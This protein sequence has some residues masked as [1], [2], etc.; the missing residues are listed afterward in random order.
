M[1]EVVDVREQQ[2]GLDP[3]R[4][5]GGQADRQHSLRPARIQHRIPELGRVLGPAIELVAELARVSGARHETVDPGHLG[6]R[7]ESEVAQRP[8][9]DSFHERGQDLARLRTLHLE[10]RHVLRHVL[11]LDVHAAI[12]GHLPEPVEVGVVARDREAVVVAQLEDR[13]VHDHLAVAVA[14]RPVTNLPDLERRHVIRE[15]D[16]RKRERV[17]ALHVPLAERRLV[18]DVGG[19]AGGLVLGRGVPEVV[20]PGP[21]FPIR[22]LGAELVLYVV[23]GTALELRHLHSP[24]PMDEFVQRHPIPGRRDGTS[25]S[26]ER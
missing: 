26:A 10:V 15:E 6:V 2:S 19:V 8:E 24:P 12:R 3:D 25:P 17:R 23:E 7:L 16:V 9:I 1:R 5:D 18:P 22:P 14:D 4:L 13:A 21:A 20:G 11:D